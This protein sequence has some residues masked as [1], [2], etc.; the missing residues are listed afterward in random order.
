M[1]I[2]RLTQLMIAFRQQIASA[3]TT[4]PP[5]GQALEPTAARELLE[6]MLLSRHLDAAAL[7]LRM[8]GAGHYTIA[9]SG[10]EGNAVLGR[11]T[12][13]S[14]P[15]L[16]HYRSGALQLNYSPLSIV[17]SIPL[18]RLGEN[19]IVRYA[20]L[21]YLRARLRR[22]VAS[23]DRAREIQRETLLAKIAR[24]ADSA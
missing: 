16:V 3:I 15:S 4:T 1:S 12:R 17:R 20:Y 5:A 24:N 10:H 8:R 6:S 2:E 13:T 9:S 19:L 14:D 18:S 11:L 22:F 23:A 7:E 21:A